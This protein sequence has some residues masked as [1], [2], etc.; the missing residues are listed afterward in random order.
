MRIKCYGCAVP[1]CQLCS[2]YIDK[3]YPKECGPIADFSG[4]AEFLADISWSESLYLSSIQAAQEICRNRGAHFLL[5]FTPSLSWVENLSEHEKFLTSIKFDPNEIG[6]EY[7]GERIEWLRNYYLNKSIIY[8]ELKSFNEQYINNIFEDVKVAR[9]SNGFPFQGEFK[10]KWVNVIAGKRLTTEQPEKADRTIHVFGASEIYGFGCEDNHTIPSFIQHSVNA[11]K[12]NNP[13][14][15]TWIVQ[16]YGVRAATL[17]CNLMRIWN[18][19]ISSGDIV[20]ALNN[21]MFIPSD[22]ADD[23]TPIKVHKFYDIAEYKRYGI[24][25][26]DLRK[27]FER[28]H[29]YG[30]LFFD[31]D[32]F[33][34][35]GNR[36]FS[37]KI[38]HNILPVICSKNPIAKTKKISPIK[39]ANTNT[40]EI[41]R[42]ELSAYLDFLK[43][44]IFISD[45]KNPVIGAT[46]MN[47]NPFTAGH[48]HLV[49][50]AAS[51][52]DH[53]YIF[54]VQEDKSF[55]PFETRIRLVK[56]G[57]KE[58]K[59]VTVLPSGS[60]MVSAESFPEYFNKE[61]CQDLHIDATQDILPFCT[62]IAPLLGITRRFVGEEPLCKITAQHN[63]HLK[64]ICPDYGIKLIEI[65]RIKFKNLIISASLVRELYKSQDW[66]HLYQL[67]PESTFK[68]LLK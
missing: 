27:I 26:L 67:V 13:E 34:Y 25:F 49:N 10:S 3:D 21:R 54:V 56:E 12:H 14:T 47:A 55:F 36:I 63:K 48:A 2:E 60:F 5:V 64:R 65:P 15:S 53:L 68:H 22:G 66:E 59:N 33:A 11:L 19:D 9:D 7:V 40:S 4:G 46:V 24:Q 52:V 30:E 20:I 58:L 50:I 41:L 28:P 18:A 39:I 44:N 57:V 62:H 6:K 38:F 45:K 37:Q 31:Q 51:Q 61:N 42:P 1:S 8:G 17:N 29:G 32:H 16:N 23:S 43:D 35:N